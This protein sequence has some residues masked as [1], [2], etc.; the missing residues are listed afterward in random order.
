MSLLW[1]ISED[2]K[3]LYLDGYIFIKC[4]LKACIIGLH[5]SGRKRNAT[6]AASENYFSGTMSG[7]FFFA[8][9]V[10]VGKM[11]NLSAWLAGDPFS[12]N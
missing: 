8:L 10:Y 3:I 11:Y 1:V 7:D 5:R 6:L 9:L 2:R 12:Q 4:L